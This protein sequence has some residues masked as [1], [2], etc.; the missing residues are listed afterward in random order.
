MTLQMKDALSADAAELDRFDP[1]ERALAG[2]KAVQRVEAGGV[3]RVNGG[4][5]VP[6]PPVDINRIGH[7]KP[8]NYGCASTRERSHLY[9]LCRVQSKPRR[10]LLALR[11]VDATR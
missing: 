9:Q 3:A 11:R 4:A 5:L 1:V 10:P 7:A 6:I 8:R 2:A